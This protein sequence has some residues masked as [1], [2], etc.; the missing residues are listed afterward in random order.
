M[1]EKGVIVTKLCGYIIFK[2]NIEKIKI[3]CS[4]K[5]LCIGTEIVYN[6]FDRLKIM[7]NEM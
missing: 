1:Y 4:Y 6:N 3:V 5:Y 7:R 2:F